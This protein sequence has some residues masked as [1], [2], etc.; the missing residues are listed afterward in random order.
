V[1]TALDEQVTQF[2]MR[3]PQ[4]VQMDPVMANP[5]K[6]LMQ[7]VLDEHISQSLRT[8]LQKTQSPANTARYLLIQLVHV[9]FELQV[10]QSVIKALQRSQ[11]VP[12]IA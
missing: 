3:E 1:Q 11:S 12:F 8:T 4:G 7:V 9:M 2:I 10:A 6:Q 5:E